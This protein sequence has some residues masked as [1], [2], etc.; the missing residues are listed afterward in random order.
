MTLLL[1]NMLQILV[2]FSRYVR[3]I[4]LQ[5]IQWY[6]QHNTEPSIYKLHKAHIFISTNSES[7]VRYLFKIFT[8]SYNV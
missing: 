8:M 5:G 3:N 2:M 6:Q 4:C 7:K 1:Q